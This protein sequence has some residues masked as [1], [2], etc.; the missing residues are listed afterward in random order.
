MA[1]SIEALE[2]DHEL[3]KKLARDLGKA[4]KARNAHIKE[5]I[6]AGVTWRAAADAA[7]I[8][9]V[10]VGKIMKRPETAPDEALVDPRTEEQ[11]AAAQRVAG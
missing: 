10:Q 9:S 2:S 1:R 6:S 7:G 4:R 11:P 8:S 5:A 3:V